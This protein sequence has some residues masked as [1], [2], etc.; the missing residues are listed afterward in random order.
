MS[1]GDK[2]QPSTQP[3]Q[4]RGTRDEKT[5]TEVATVRG[6]GE[7][8]RNGNAEH[9]MTLGVTNACTKSEH[10]VCCWIENTKPAR[11]SERALTSAR[12]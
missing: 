6:R 2:H 10:S 8:S 5:D 3:S 7:R 12:I 1:N 9:A 4:A 11:R